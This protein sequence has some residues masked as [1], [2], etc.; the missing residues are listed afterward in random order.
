MPAWPAGVQDEHSAE[1]RAGP[2]NHSGP[3]LQF[4][5]LHREPNQPRGGEADSRSLPF[6]SLPLQKGMDVVKAGLSEY[7]A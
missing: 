1:L 5:V 6:P 7:T 3:V 4:P 2:I